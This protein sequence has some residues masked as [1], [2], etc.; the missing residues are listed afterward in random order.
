MSIWLGQDEP[1]VA[2]SDYRM[3]GVFE[4]LNQNFK[5]WDSG[6]SDSLKEMNQLGWGL[7]APATLSKWE[8]EE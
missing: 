3:F 6:S 7:I 5:W 4:S 1:E 2:F 8:E